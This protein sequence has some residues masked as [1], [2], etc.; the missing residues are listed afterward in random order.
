MDGKKP[1]T[2]CVSWHPNSIGEVPARGSLALVVD[3]LKL[4]CSC[5]EV[6]NV[7]LAKGI[8]SPEAFFY[9]VSEHITAFWERLNGGRETG[10]NGL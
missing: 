6:G 3:T 4:R 9:L 1:D 5:S 10:H 7:R 8:L 2:I